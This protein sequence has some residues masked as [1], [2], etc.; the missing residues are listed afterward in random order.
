MIDWLGDLEKHIQQYDGD[1]DIAWNMIRATEQVLEEYN[2]KM[3]Y[4]D[5]EAKQL[6]LVAVFTDHDDLWEAEGFLLS[7]GFIVKE[8]DGNELWIRGVKQ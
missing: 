8:G 4:N 1:D 2:V 7:H 3:V 5:R 6:R